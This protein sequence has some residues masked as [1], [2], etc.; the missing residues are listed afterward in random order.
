MTDELTSTPD[1]SGA[2]DASAPVPVRDGSTVRHRRL[3]DQ[4]WQEKAA[5][6]PTE[7]HRVDP[8]IFFPTPAETGKI[9]AAKALCTQCPVRQPCLDIALETGDTH[10]IRGGLTEEEREALHQDRVARIER[11][12]IQ[13][14]LAGHDIALTRAER[15]TLLHTA[16]HQGISVQRLAWLLKCTEGHAAKL[17][18]KTRRALNPTTTRRI[19][20]FGTAA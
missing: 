2:Q 11:T 10:G 17:Y 20:D 7:H 5:C 15:R 12:R 3:G 18:R 13:E 16:V 14:A 1:T 9:T 8:E 19:S 6:R 4:R